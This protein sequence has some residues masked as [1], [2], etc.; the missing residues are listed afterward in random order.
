MSLGIEQFLN[1]DVRA[2]RAKLG[3]L[4]AATRSGGHAI[5][6]A[7]CLLF[8]GS[9][10]LQSGRLDEALDLGK[11][12]I[13]AV[14]HVDHGEAA[15]RGVMALLQGYVLYERNDL[16]A[17]VARLEALVERPASLVPVAIKVAVFPLLALAYHAQGNDK[18]ARATIEKGSA[19]WDQT[20]EV[21]PGPGHGVET[22][23]PPSAL[24]CG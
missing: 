22:H 14:T 7:T 21:A 9:A 8:L 1:G 2:A 3:D 15:V 5:D 17:A 10:N 11:R 23:L 18:A 24:V 12:G 4:L 19:I 16:D 20:P 6:Y 13:S